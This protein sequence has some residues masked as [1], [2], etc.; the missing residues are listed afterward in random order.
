MDDGPARDVEEQAAFGLWGGGG[1][2][3][4]GRKGDGG[5]GEGGGVAVGGE[6]GKF[7][8]GEEVGCC[9]GEGEGYDEGVE[10]L[11]QEGV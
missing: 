10:V 2:G 3:R 4:G 9:G 5:A 8:A 7:G 11:G 1:L 6:D